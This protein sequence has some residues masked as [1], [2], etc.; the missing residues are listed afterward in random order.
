MTPC[1]YTIVLYVW[2][3]AYFFCGGLVIGF[4][5][6]RSNCKNATGHFMI[7][8]GLCLSSLPSFLS[9][10]R[11]FTRDMKQLKPEA[12]SVCFVVVVVSVYFPPWVTVSVFPK[13]K[14]FLLLESA[15]I[16]KKYVTLERGM[17]E[18]EWV[19]KFKFSCGLYLLVN[20]R[21]LCYSFKFF[22]LFTTFLF[23]LFS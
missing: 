3:I 4:V 6:R 18:K 22:L 14:I 2:T 11:F 7:L 8:F 5:N 15:R 20:K 1:L 16:G 13:K 17:K 12:L 10:Y 19:L 9:L 23:I 21:L